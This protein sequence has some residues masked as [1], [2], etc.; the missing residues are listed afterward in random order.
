MSFLGFTL[1]CSRVFLVVPGS[2]LVVLGFTLGSFL[3]APGGFLVVL[4]FIPFDEVVVEFEHGFYVL[5]MT[6][7]GEGKMLSLRHVSDIRD[8]GDAYYW[9]LIL[10]ETYMMEARVEKRMRLPMSNA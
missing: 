8:V 9:V 4:G 5:L 1:G 7:C 10:R 3:V 2:F 6:S